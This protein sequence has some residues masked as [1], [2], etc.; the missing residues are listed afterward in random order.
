MQNKTFDPNFGSPKMIGDAIVEMLHAAVGTPL[1]LR[2][3]KLTIDA[4]GAVL[5]AVDPKGAVERWYCPALPENRNFIESAMTLMDIYRPGVSRYQLVL[6]ATGIPTIERS[7]N[8]LTMPVLDLWSSVFSSI[9]LGAFARV[10]FDGANTEEQEPKVVELSDNWHARKL[11]NQLA[12]HADAPVFI[13]LADGTEVPLANSEVVVAE[14]GTV[15]V[16]VRVS[17]NVTMTVRP[18]Q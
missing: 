6:N 16:R 13:V 5:H 1:S 9:R 12:N 17:N 11:A 4:N 18:Q 3:V 7:S 8:L 15:K 14:D 10:I 2:E